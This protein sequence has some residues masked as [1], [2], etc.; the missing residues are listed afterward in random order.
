MLQYRLTSRHL[1]REVR[2]DMEGSNAPTMTSADALFRYA[3]VSQ[4][5]A[6]ELGGQARSAA[7][8]DVSRRL[9]YQPDGVARRISERTLYRW[10]ALFEEKGLAG[11]DP[12][13]RP[14]MDSSIVLPSEFLDYVVWQRR[15]D[16][17][18]SIPEL[19]ARARLEGKLAQLMPGHD[20][21]RQTCWR[22]LRRMG[23]STGRRKK[24]RD[25]DTRPFAYPHRLDMIL[26]DGKH[27]RVGARR[28]RRVAVFF[29]D[30]ATRYGL[31]VVVGNRGEKAVLFLRGL[32]ELI[33]KYG[34]AGI[35]RSA[36]PRG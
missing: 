11:L 10:L 31:H 16:P 15:D 5:R 36:I 4:V 29:L 23:L 13:P 32:Y 25:R 3:V 2:V 34:I 17:D 22:A 12:V 1:T 19:I 18:A 20:V 28:L 8:R 7:V 27:F 9:R 33:R 35:Y 14:R 21:V 26:A 30:D 24:R 6:L